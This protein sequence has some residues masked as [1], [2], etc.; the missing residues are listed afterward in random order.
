MVSGVVHVQEEVVRG[1]RSS[2]RIHSLR[3]PPK[4]GERGRS[5]RG[6]TAQAPPPV[7]R[8]P[9]ASRF[10][11]SASYIAS[12]ST[13]PPPPP[14]QPVS[15]SGYPVATAQLG[16]TYAIPAG[17]PVVHQPPPA[18]FH[19]PTPPPPP[20]S[21]PSYAGTQSGPAA[22]PARGPGPA[23]VPAPPGAPPAAAWRQLA[24]VTSA[25]PR[26]MTDDYTSQLL[27]NPPC[28]SDKRTVE[29]PRS[30]PSTP[31]PLDQLPLLHTLPP[32][33]PAHRLPPTLLHHDLRP[34]P[35]NLPARLR[36]LL[37]PPLLSSI[38]P[39]RPCPRP[40][41]HPPLRQD[42]LHLL[43]Q[44]PRRS[45]LTRLPRPSPLQTIPQNPR[46]RLPRLHLRPTSPSPSSLR[47]LW[48]T[49]RQ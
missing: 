46:S 29:R 45:Q 15:Y 6:G 28:T 19:R 40:F 38:Y 26:E 31:A 48:R 42:P 5:S 30:L 21:Y 39:L 36:F 37:P 33:L 2:T 32:T 35:P 7:A 27:H 3:M 24:F 44:R 18:L 41:P 14:V 9:G 20:A 4:R 43:H 13:A 49:R 16:A 1:S 11:P 23:F 17:P 34:R 10:A 47:S 25:I 22:Y 12:H 8:P